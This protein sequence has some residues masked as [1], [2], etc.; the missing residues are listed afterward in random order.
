MKEVWEGTFDI[1]KAET[2]WI[3]RE[4]FKRLKDEP[5]A[6]GAWVKYGWSFSKTG[7]TYAY[8]PETEEVK[9]AVF[10]ILLNYMN[11]LPINN[12]Y[13]MHLL[14][15]SIWRWVAR[16]YNLMIWDVNS[17]T[18]KRRKRE[19]IFHMT[20]NHNIQN[21]NKL[22]SIDTTNLSLTNGSYNEVNIAPNSVVYCDILYNATNGK[23]TQYSTAPFDR[24]AFLDWAATR[25]FPVY[26]SEYNIAD[27]RFSGVLC[28]AKHKGNVMSGADTLKHR[29]T[30]YEK[31]YWNGVV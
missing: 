4:D 3:S 8:P 12:I 11:H 13:D 17:I 15:A 20:L 25:P 29:K 28:V 23:P 27:A 14:W 16:K 24:Q 5:T 10:T 9:K 31:L 2:T 22:K 18:G 26:I 19:K 30:V 1:H 7:D 6:W 21:V